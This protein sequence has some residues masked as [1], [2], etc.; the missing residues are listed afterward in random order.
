[1]NKTDLIQKVKVLQGLILPPQIDN[2]SQL[3]NKEPRKGEL[4]VAQVK[5]QMGNYRSRWKRQMDY[6]TDI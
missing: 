3:I 4:I 5:R 1:M 6:R 2:V